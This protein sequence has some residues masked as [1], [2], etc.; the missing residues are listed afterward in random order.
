MMAT[1]AKTWTSKRAIPRLKKH[2]VLKEKCSP[3]LIT[4]L[5]YTWADREVGTYFSQYNHELDLVNLLSWL[6]I[7]IITDPEL[8]SISLCIIRTNATSSTEFVFMNREGMNR[9]F[10]YMYDCLFHYLHVR[11]LFDDFTISV[12][13]IL[14]VALHT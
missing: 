12:L 5:R 6:S 2:P 8:C 13:R 7:S 4:L 14:N 9:D 1:T 11:V 10:F 3:P